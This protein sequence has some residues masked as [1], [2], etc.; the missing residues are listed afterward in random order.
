M[1]FKQYLNAK[2][3]ESSIRLALI[4]SLGLSTIAFIIVC[5]HV[6]WNTIEAQP[7]EWLGLAAFVGGLASFFLAAV[8]GK[9]TQ[10]K[11]EFNAYDY[12]QGQYGGLNTGYYQNTMYSAQPDAT[13]PP[14][15]NPELLKG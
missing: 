15:E 8:Y 3:N 14:T 13:V 9:I 7:I 2:T 10:Q 6:V 4:W 11:N 5:F 1:P 12:N